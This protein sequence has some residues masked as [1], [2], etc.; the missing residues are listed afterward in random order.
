MS[1]ASRTC[2]HVAATFIISALREISSLHT[3]SLYCFWM[4]RSSAARRAKCFQHPVPG[5]CT[6][7]LF[8]SQIPACVPPPPPMNEQI[9]IQIGRVTP[10]V[11]L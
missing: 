1:G 9:L 6:S 3:L 10:M 2:C 11:V 4:T 7:A 5:P 8:G